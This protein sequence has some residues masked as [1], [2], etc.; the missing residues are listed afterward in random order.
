MWRVGHK[1]GEEQSINLSFRPIVLKLQ[2]AS[3]SPGLI[4]TNCCLSFHPSIPKFLI[5][6]VWCRAQEFVFPACSLVLLLLLLLLIG[7]YIL[8]TSVLESINMTDSDNTWVWNI[9]PWDL[10]MSNRFLGGHSI[11]RLEIRGKGQVWR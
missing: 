10:W 3:S 4:K 6:E 7:D 8:R 2:H 1:L 9:V 11:D 5:Q